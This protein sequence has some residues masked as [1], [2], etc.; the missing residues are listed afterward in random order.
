MKKQSFTHSR[1]PKFGMRKLSIGLASCMLGMMFLATGHVSAEDNAGYEGE[2]L[3]IIPGEEYNQR[4][5]DI[6][7]FQAEKKEANVRYTKWLDGVNVSE[8]DFRKVVDGESV[9]Y[10]APL[11]NDRGYY[12]INKDFNQDSDKCSAAVAANMFHYWFDRNKD[13]IA[14]FLQQKPGEHG[15]IKFKDGTSIDLSDFLNAYESDSGYRDKSKFFDFVSD[16]FSGPVWTDKLLDAYIN[17]YGYIDKYARNNEDSSKNTSTINFFKEVFNQKILTNVWSIRNQNDFSYYLRDALYTGKAIG[18]SYGP[19]GV[20]NALGHIISVWGA[21]LDGEGNVVAVYVTDSD[22][23]KVTIGEERERI[24]LKRYKVSTD[25]W[26][27]VRLTAYQTT[28]NT[29]GLL[30]SVYTLDTGKYDWADYFNKTN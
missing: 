14:R 1:K 7:D 28:Q 3:R 8:Y 24:G 6:E 4:L 13:S 22:D 19:A 2:I 16:K 12:D 10:A 5:K 25:D 30:R 20:Y 23:K 15:V 17:G 26:G 21:D 29:G 11:L 9:Y 27:R 18:L